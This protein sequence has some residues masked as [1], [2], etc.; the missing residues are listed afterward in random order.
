[1]DMLK[2]AE[3]RGQS[4]IVIGCTGPGTV[5][6]VDSL[7]E[8]FNRG[9]A[10]VWTSFASSDIEQLRESACDPVTGNTNGKIVAS[11]NS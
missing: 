6:T 1:M 5:T 7:S 3:E 9:H 11:P 2:Q 4:V 8:P 10:G